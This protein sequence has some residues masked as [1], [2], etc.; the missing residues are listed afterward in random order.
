[1]KEAKDKS[2]QFRIPVSARKLLHAF[3][4]LCELN[5]EVWKLE[6]LEMIAIKEWQDLEKKV[7]PEGGEIGVD[8]GRVIIETS[9][10]QH[11]SSTTP[12]QPEAER[13]QSSSQR[14]QQDAME[15]DEI[16]PHTPEAGS[17][18]NAPK[19]CLKYEYKSPETQQ[20]YVDE[21]VWIP[22]G[23]PVSSTI[24]LETEQEI[25][26][27]ILNQMALMSAR[28]AAGNPL[29]LPW[30]TINTITPLSEYS[31]PYLACKLFPYLFPQ[32]K[33]DYWSPHERPYKLH[34][35]P[36]SLKH[37][38]NFLLEQDDNRFS[39]DPRFSFFM[40]NVTQRHTINNI[41]SFVFHGII[42]PQHCEEHPVGHKWTVR[43]I[44]KLIEKDPSIVDNS[45][46]Y[47]N[48]LPG[49]TISNKSNI[50][51]T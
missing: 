31:E 13:P 2:H 47:L 11:P 15:V 50:R 38:T 24:S 51:H 48:T 27:K 16:N 40:L 20:Q 34:N 19:V 44:R 1:M 21:E 22:L 49:L 28:S 32:P 45:L 26:R 37:W 35:Q 10:D 8:F 25:R 17:N 6:D 5:P 3:H 30:P 29:E 23:M 41:G 33:L 7:G 39:S 4:K 14:H 43:D 9:I 36:I 46:R 12:E 42:K 18:T